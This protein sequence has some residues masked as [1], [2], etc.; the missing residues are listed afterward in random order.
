MI[1]KSSGLT[2]S[3]LKKKLEEKELIEK[4]F[5]CK[6]LPIRMIFRK[7][8]EVE[9][10]E[11]LIKTINNRLNIIGILNKLEIIEKI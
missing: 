1:K 4:K 6:F 11:K 7:Q 10:I 5:K 2:S 9:T 3:N 8:S